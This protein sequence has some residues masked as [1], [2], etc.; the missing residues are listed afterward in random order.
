LSVDCRTLDRLLASR[1]GS[2]PHLRQPQL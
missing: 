1:G 2:R